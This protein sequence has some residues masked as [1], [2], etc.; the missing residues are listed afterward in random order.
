MKPRLRLSILI[1]PI[2][3][4]RSKKRQLFFLKNF[5]NFTKTRFMSLPKWEK[6]YRRDENVRWFHDQTFFRDQ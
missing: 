4:N 6:N 2:K 1:L 5:Y 3:H